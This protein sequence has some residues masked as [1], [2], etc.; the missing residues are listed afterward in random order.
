[1]KMNFIEGTNIWWIQ[2]YPFSDKYKLASKELAFYLEGIDN[3]KDWAKYKTETP[4][5]DEANYYCKP[6][7]IFCFKINE[8][9][10]RLYRSEQGKM[11]LCEGKDKVLKVAKTKLNPVKGFDIIS[12]DFFD[13]NSRHANICHHI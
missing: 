6:D 7:T 12:S 3:G 1:M 8:K 13:I 11:M 9:E 5:T 4:I 2:K 10:Y